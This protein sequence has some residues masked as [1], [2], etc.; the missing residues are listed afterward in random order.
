MLYVTVLMIL[1]SETA[2]LTFLKE[3][4]LAGNPLSL[5]AAFGC[6]FL[7][8]IFLIESFRYEGMGIVNVL[9]SAFSVILVFVTGM[10]FFAET[11]TLS[12]AAGV[13]FIIVGIVLLRSCHAKVEKRGRQYSHM[14]AGH[15]PSC[16]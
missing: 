16:I 12:D 14:S 6:Y 15:H 1:L 10:I 13:G 4:S 9:W 7:V 11:I 2:A 5:I 8:N 3:Y